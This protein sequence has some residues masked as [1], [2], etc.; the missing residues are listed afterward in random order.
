MF[1]HLARVRLVVL[2]TVLALS[3]G[4]LPPLLAQD[5]AAPVASASVQ[6]ALLEAYALI[7]AEQLDDAL[8][9][10]DQIQAEHAYDQALIEQ[11]RAFTYFSMQ[12]HAASIAAFQ[13]AIATGGLTDAQTQDF[14]YSVLQVSIAS[15]DRAA[16][17]LALEEAQ[18]P[19]QPESAF[20]TKLFAQ[21]YMELEEYETAL[22]HARR[23]R[24]LH[25]RPDQFLD[26]MVRYLETLTAD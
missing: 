19:A 16:I 5:E 11:G 2:A 3:G 15:A 8:A 13:A 9:H 6:A 21:A 20:N 18:T 17:L 4:G 10:L 23:A 26:R 7:D 22:G 14:E 24:E 1:N 12:N 25:G